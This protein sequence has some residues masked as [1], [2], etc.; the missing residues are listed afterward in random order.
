MFKMVPSSVRE[1]YKILIL[2]FQI[3]VFC[4]IPGDL[5]MFVQEHQK[6]LVNKESHQAKEGT[7]LTIICPPHSYTKYPVVTTCRENMWHPALPNCSFDLGKTIN[8]NFKS[9]INYYIDPS[10]TK[11]L[12]Y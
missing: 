10:L 11:I 12:K 9:F 3:L 1:F 5:L 7:V 6:H 4:Y 2:N 8:E